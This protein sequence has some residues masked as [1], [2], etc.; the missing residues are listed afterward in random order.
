MIDSNGGKE[1]ILR[2]F[3]GQAEGQIER[4]EELLNRLGTPLGGL[5]LLTQKEM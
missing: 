2:S 5:N 4:I 1:S 3:T